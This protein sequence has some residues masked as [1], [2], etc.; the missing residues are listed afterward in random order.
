MIGVPRVRGM[1][2]EPRMV[3]DERL[4]DVEGVVEVFLIL[5]EENTPHDWKEQSKY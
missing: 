4:G 2:G 5:G 3:V 1:G